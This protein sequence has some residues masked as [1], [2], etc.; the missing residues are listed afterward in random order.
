MRTYFRAKLLPG[1]LIRPAEFRVG[2]VKKVVITLF[3]AGGPIHLWSLEKRQHDIHRVISATLERH[4]VAP[5]PNR[6]CRCSPQRHLPD[7]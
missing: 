3:S 6:V 4:R 2:Q 5:R 7:R 1:Q